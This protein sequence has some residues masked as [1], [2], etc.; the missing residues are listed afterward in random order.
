MLNAVTFVANG[1]SVVLCDLYNGFCNTVL[2]DIDNECHYA[3]NGDL[4][5][6]PQ[7]PGKVNQRR[8]IQ[9]QTVSSPLNNQVS[10][11]IMFV[12]KSEQKNTRI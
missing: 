10:Y 1:Q 8:V 2:L 7:S 5:Q 9:I 4:N 11:P 6:G 12:R 3:R